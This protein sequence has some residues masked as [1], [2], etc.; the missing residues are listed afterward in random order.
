MSGRRKKEEAVIAMVSA[1]K[2]VL[3][4]LAVAIEVF[5]RVR[6]DRIIFSAIPRNPTPS[7]EVISL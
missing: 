1:I 2:N 6:T 3:S 7:P 4:V 5:C